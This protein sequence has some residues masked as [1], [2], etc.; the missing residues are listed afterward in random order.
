[1]TFGLFLPI[2]YAKVSHV[3]A[4]EPYLCKQEDC[5]L[6]PFGLE[7]NDTLIILSLY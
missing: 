1:M 3:T 5:L 7:K 4:P 2:S 6:Q